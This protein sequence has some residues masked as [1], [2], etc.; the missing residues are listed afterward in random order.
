MPPAL[1]AIILRCIERD[2][3]MRYQS[4]DELGTALAGLRA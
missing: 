2:A 1:E 4:A 3:A